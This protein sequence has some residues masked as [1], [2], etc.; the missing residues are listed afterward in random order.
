MSSFRQRFAHLLRARWLTSVVAGILFIVALYLVCQHRA[1]PLAMLPYLLLLAC[2][3]T[4]LFMHGGHRRRTRG[5][6]EDSAGPAETIGNHL[7]LAAK[8]RVGSDMQ[9]RGS[10]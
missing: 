6:D 1:S 9:L 3:L 2:P 8:Q 4:H 5:Y 7:V 10:H